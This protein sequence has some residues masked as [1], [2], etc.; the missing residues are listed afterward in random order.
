[1][2]EALQAIDA[3]SAPVASEG[4]GVDPAAR[5]TLTSDERA[6][7][8]YNPY[9]TRLL[10]LYS[11]A[12]YT[13]AGTRGLDEIAKLTYVK[14]RLDERLA[15]EIV[16]GKFRLV[17]ISGNAGDGKTAF[18]QQ[19]EQEFEVRGVAVTRQRN[20]A[21]WTHEGLTYR[22]NY[23]ASQD[24]HDRRSDTVLEEFFAPF[25]GVL[26]DLQ[27]QPEV[28]LIAINEGRLLDFFLHGP[29]AKHFAGL[30]EALRAHLHDRAPLPKGMLLVNLNLRA[31][32]VR[33]RRTEGDE[34]GRSLVDAQLDTMLDGALWQPCE[35]CA[36]KLRCPT[37]PLAAG[38]ANGCVDSTRWSTS[39]ADSTS[40]CATSARRSRGSSCVITAATT[41][42]ACSATTRPTRSNSSPRSTTPMPSRRI[43]SRCTRRWKTAS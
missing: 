13:N 24:D 41:W 32:A 35:G 7:R 2:R 28:R 30:G 18:L 22:S 34:G 1:M 23:D 43:S 37:Q 21:S 14:T 3:Y 6:K 27:A 20:S 5:L 40:R 10:T 36:H 11:Q 17:L 31:V 38:F 29:L 33:A 12:R 25:A 16:D 4:M 8:D 26:G 42:R 15:P 9:V 39:D 19:L